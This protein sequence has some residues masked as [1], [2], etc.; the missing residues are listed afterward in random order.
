MPITQWSNS[1]ATKYLGAYKCPKDQS[2]QYRVLKQKCDNFAKVINCSHLT[3]SETACFYW[4]IYRLS[5]NYVL[6][7]TYFTED[8][9]SKIQ[10]KAHSSMV[11]RSGYC[12]TTPKEIIYGPKQYGGAGYFHL[13]DD[14][15]YG[16]VKIFLKVWRSPHTQLGQLL[17]VAMAWCHFS[18]GTGTSLLL[19]VQTKL[20]HL[21]SKWISSLQQFLHQVNG[22]ITLDNTYMQ[23][24]QR[25][26]D[27]YIMDLALYCGSK[28][29][30]ADIKR[31]NYCR[32]HLNIL[33]L[34]NITM[35]CGSRLDP[36]A[37]KGDKNSLFS[38]T[39]NHNI[40]QPRPR[41][42]TWKPWR[43][44]LTLQCK[45]TTSATC[46]HPPSKRMEIKCTRP[47]MALALLL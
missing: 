31:I 44:L 24:K 1:H 28:F 11:E 47:P 14:Q 20:P 33:L 7:S 42:Q 21:E 35:P 45:F 25:V 41:E 12:R 43:R 10:G 17:R 26:H 5:A 16:Q 36:A 39:T 38:S 37:Y 9:L 18:A 4:A 32:L 19:N 29:K 22:H 8:E 27:R 34:S 23:P 3:R 13:Y 30:P 15:G 46:S 6:P 40:H 2:A